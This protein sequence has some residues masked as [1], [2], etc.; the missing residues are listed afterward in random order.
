MGT[1]ASMKR[2]SNGRRPGV[3]ADSVALALAVLLSVAPYVH[4]LG[5]YSDDWAFF[6]AYANAGSQTVEGYFEA[7]N[8]AH[9]AMRPVQLWLCA[10]LYRVFG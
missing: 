2:E 10:V 5:F 6:G 3:L 1:P 9:H 4:R 8:S 7:S